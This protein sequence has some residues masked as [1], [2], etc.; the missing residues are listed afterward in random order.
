MVFHFWAPLPPPAC[1]HFCFSRTHCFIMFPEPWET[2]GL[3]GMRACFIFLVRFVAVWLCWE[4]NIINRHPATLGRRYD[5]K[6]FFFFWSKIFLAFT[7]FCARFVLKTGQDGRRCEIHNIHQHES[8]HLSESLNNFQ[9]SY[10][11]LQIFIGCLY[12]IQYPYKYQ[13]KKTS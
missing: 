8:I 5:S 1:P 11:F 12:I 13:I 9:L 2:T 3:W 6:T 10:F 7:F 4:E